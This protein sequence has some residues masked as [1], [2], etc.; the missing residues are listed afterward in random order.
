[1]VIGFTTPYHDDFMIDLPAPWITI[2][3]QAL[4]TLNS[5]HIERNTPG[6]NTWFLAGL[7]GMCPRNPGATKRYF[8]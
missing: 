2:M 3:L 6:H 8:V 4:N 7:I 1:M 5:Y